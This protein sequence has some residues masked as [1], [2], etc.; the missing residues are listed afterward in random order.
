MGHIELLNGNR[1]EA[2][3]NFKNGIELRYDNARI[4][5][6]AGTCARMKTNYSES[7]LYY[8][9]A[10]EKFENSD[11]TNSEREDIKANFKLVNQY[12]IERKRENIIPQITIKYPLP[13]KRVYSHGIGAQ[14]EKLNSLL[15]TR[16]LF[17]R[18]KLTDFQKQLI[19]Q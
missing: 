15:R 3:R 5:Y 6:E 4:Y 13:I 16:A 17:K 18:W 9:R 14:F 2:L 10:I 8:Q 11:L 19:P 7:K 12:E 1:D